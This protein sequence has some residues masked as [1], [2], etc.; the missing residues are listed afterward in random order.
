MEQLVKD[1]VA[2]EVNI[3]LNILL[4]NSPVIP[5][6]SITSRLRKELL[7]LL[8]EAYKLIPKER[9]KKRMEFLEAL[10]LKV[11]QL[12]ESYN[13]VNKQQLAVEEFKSYI[14]N[15]LREHKESYKIFKSPAHYKTILLYNWILPPDLRKEIRESRDVEKNTLLEALK[16][17]IVN[18]VAS[19]E[20]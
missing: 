12:S 8:S 4:E 15:E 5:S 9:K 19:V 16:K 10:R 2:F 17:S 13:V 6:K 7:K 14:I 3:L 18:L 20:S 11:N 1:N